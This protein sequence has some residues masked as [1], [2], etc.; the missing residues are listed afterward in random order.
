MSAAGFVAVVGAWTGYLATVPSGNVPARPIGGITLQITGIC[1][2][3][4]GIVWSLRDGGS[5]GVAVI[6]P[7]AVALMMGPLF[8][9]L[10]TQRKTPI[11]ELKVEVADALLPFAAT[12]SA[13]AAFHTDS[14]AG[15]RTLLKFFRGSW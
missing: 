1:L 10:L 14:L 9:Y 12:T 6:A 3:I 15:K 8:L 5:P 2:A 4:A 11:G 7:S 13:G